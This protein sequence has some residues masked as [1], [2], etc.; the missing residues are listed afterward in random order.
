MSLKT[1]MTTDFRPEVEIMPF[2]RMREEKSAGNGP[3]SSKY[4]TSTYGANKY[5][6]AEIVQTLYR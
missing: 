6:T 1:T 3:R 4:S 2:L 5:K